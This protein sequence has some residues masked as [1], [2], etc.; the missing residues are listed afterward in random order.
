MR[1]FETGMYPGNWDRCEVVN[2]LGERIRE[3]QGSP[4][5]VKEL[6]AV[7]RGMSHEFYSPKLISTLLS[8][9]ETDRMQRD[10]NGGSLLHRAMENPCLATV[11]VIL[12]ETYLPAKCEKQA[13]L[14]LQ[15]NDG[16]KA[17][18]RAT[19]FS[20]DGSPEVIEVSFELEAAR[21]CAPPTLQP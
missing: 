6:E 9:P 12:S 11:K 3:K 10:K 7:W 21:T 15:N 13:Y 18:V 5:L 17:I 8:F 19:E 20:E 14:K 2:F 16:K 4:Q 1:A